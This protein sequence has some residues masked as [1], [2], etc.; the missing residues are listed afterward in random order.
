MRH[1]DGLQALL[2]TLQSFALQIL[3]FLVF[4]IF[5]ILALRVAK[6]RM[7]GALFNWSSSRD[8][9]SSHD[10]QDRKR[11]KKKGF[12]SRIE[13]FALLNGDARA[14]TLYDFHS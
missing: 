6:F 1:Q 9:S 13:P 5:T 14:G 11:L 10:S 12:M 4:P 2:T 7:F 3:P 8:S